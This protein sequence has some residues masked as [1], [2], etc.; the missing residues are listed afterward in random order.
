MNG[1]VRPQA[2][3]WHCRPARAAL[4][5]LG[6]VLAVPVALAGCATVHE[7]G[8]QGRDATPFDTAERECRAVAAADT[9]AFERCMAQH[10]WTRPVQ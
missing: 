1:T 2:G 9:A 7:P 5:A 6:L 3:A 4:R 8:W 10:G